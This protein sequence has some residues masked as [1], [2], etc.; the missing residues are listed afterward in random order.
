MLWRGR[1]DSYYEYLLKTW[2]L[3][4]KRV[5]PA[6]GAATLAGHVISSSNAHQ[7]SVHHLDEKW[8]CL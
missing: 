7:V 8:F 1:A 6:T 3:R 2:L 4:D 5:R